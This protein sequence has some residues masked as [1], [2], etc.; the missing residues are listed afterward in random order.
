MNCSGFPPLIM[1]FSCYGQAQYQAP[2]ILEMVRCC[3]QEML[4]SGCYMGPRARLWE[5]ESS[6]KSFWIYMMEI[7]AR[8][9]FCPQKNWVKSVLQTCY[10]ANLILYLTK[11]GFYF[12]LFLYLG[13]HGHHE[14]PD[15]FL[16]T[17]ARMK[18]VWCLKEL[19]PMQILTL[20][21]PVSCL[22][23]M[24]FLSYV[25]SFLCP[26]QSMWRLGT[27]SNPLK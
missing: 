3:L 22:L 11:V 2:W 21:S 20:A 5:G 16:P 27:A 6:S 23:G 12:P 17:Y 13:V 15:D 26:F 1:F 9:I 10:T 24:C 4:M 18:V 8:Q 25:L 7:T 19:K 14:V